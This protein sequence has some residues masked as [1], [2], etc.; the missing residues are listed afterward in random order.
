MG[1]KAQIVSVRLNGTSHTEHICVPSIQFKR[2]SMIVP[3]GVHFLPLFITTLPNANFSHDRL[4]FPFLLMSN[5]VV[6][7]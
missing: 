3:S 2:Q 6:T 4:V 7:C 5:R 1:K